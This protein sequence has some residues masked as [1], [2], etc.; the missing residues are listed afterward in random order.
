VTLDV[1][2]HFAIILIV[3]DWGE[4]LGQDLRLDD[5]IRQD[6]VRLGLSLAVSV[7]CDGLEVLTGVNHKEP[8]LI[9]HHIKVVITALE[10]ECLV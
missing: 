5:E 4:E 7:A 3:R 9:S 2:A 6:C 1:H 8:G 10:L